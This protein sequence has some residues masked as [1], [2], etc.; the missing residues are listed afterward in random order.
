MLTAGVDVQDNR[1]EN[2]V[3]G[4]GLEKNSWGIQYGVI[5]GDL[6]LKET[7][8][9]LD[10]VLFKNYLREDDLQMQIMTTCIDSEGHYTSE[11]YSYCRKHEARRVWAIKDQGGSGVPVY[12]TPE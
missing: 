4:W 3:I 11:V 6:G 12:T 5:T 1:L 10:D 2:E 7:W 8:A 9:Q